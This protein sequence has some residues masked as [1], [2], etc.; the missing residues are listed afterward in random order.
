MQF[1]YT[2]NRNITGY[3]LIIIAATA[4]PENSQMETVLTGDTTV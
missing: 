4:S 3:T 2:H 1:T